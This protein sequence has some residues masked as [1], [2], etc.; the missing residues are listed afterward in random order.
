MKYLVVSDDVSISF[1]DEPKAAAA[2]LKLANETKKNVM[3]LEATP[4]FKVEFQAV[5]IPLQEVVEVPPVIS[6]NKPKSA[7]PRRDLKEVYVSAPAEE[8]KTEIIKEPEDVLKKE[9]PIIENLTELVEE[10]KVKDEKYLSDLKLLEELD[11]DLEKAKNV[12]DVSTVFYKYN[13]LFENSELKN[14]FET[15]KKNRLDVLLE[16]DLLKEL[17]TVFFQVELDNVLNR[18]PAEIKNKD[19]VKVEIEKVKRKIDKLKISASDPIDTENESKE[20]LEL[21]PDNRSFESKTVTNFNNCMTY[22]ALNANKEKLEKENPD[23]KDLINKLYFERARH[24]KKTNEPVFADR[25]K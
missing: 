16:S 19:L 25:M 23:K 8:I 14:E 20:E 4:K 9:D 13:V 7:R 11:N 17:G 15:A 24:I 21:P 2:A 22:P 3:V 5:L 10:S 18:Y 1:D 6:E 12:P